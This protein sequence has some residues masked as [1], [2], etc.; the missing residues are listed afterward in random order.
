MEIFEKINKAFGGWYEGLFG[1]SDDVRPKDILRKILTALEEH[2]KEGFDNKVYVPNQFILEISVDDEEE[3]EYLLSFLDREELETAVRRY[4][5]QNHYHIRGGLDFTIKEVE[6]GPDLA[7]REKVR[8][9][10]RYDSKIAAQKAEAP[11]PTPPP[12][13]GEAPN[14]GPPPPELGA[15][16]P[17]KGGIDRPFLPPDE[18]PTVYDVSV[19]EESESGTVPAIAAAHL[20]I[21]E[22]DKKP[23][24]FR[25]ARGSVTIGRSPRAQNDVVLENDGM[26]SRRHARIELDADGQFTLYDLNTTNGTRVNGRKVDN[27]TLKSGDEVKIG[28]TRLVFYRDQEEE[29]HQP[30]AGRWRRFEPRPASAAP[31]LV[32]TDG[33]RDVD[34]YVLGTETVIGRA[35]TNDIVIPERTVATRH[36]RIVRGAPTTLAILDGEHLSL[37]NGSKIGPGEPVALKHGDRIG[38]GTVTL[39]F[40]EAER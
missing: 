24:E 31:R 7:K 21:Y 23:Y 25:I 20:T 5:Q 15:G 16:V 30:D 34:D 36:A 22:R 27:Q 19:S 33:A 26:V 28:E 11:S 35:V 40:E 8:V 2:R 18:N 17:A 10:V 1:A 39:R 37:L 4:C 14:D 3:K 38:L 6:P 29:D 32:L 13:S 9:K 12:I